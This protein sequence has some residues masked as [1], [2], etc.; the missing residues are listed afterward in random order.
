MFG[1]IAEMLG[2]AAI[3]DEVEAVVIKQTILNVLDRRIELGIALE[4]IENLV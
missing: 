4:G 1:F 3:I 2:H